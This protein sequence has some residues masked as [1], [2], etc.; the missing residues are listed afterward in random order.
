MAAR[1]Q[2][3]RPA[4]PITSV[5]NALRLIH[6]LR[7][8]G[9]VRGRDAALE[10]GISPSSVH[11]LMAMLVFRGFA[12]QGESRSYLPGPSIGVPAISFE[13]TRRLQ[14]LVRP[15]LLA[16]SAA[17]HETTYFSILAGQTVRFLLNVESTQPL[18]TG[19]RHGFVLPAATS[20]AGRAM[21]AA[22][23]PESIDAMFATD[24]SEE[25][26][27]DAAL[28]RLHLELDRVRVQG[29]ALSVEEVETGIATMAIPLRTLPKDPPAAISISV[30][31]LRAARLTEPATIDAIIA[32]RDAIESEVERGRSALGAL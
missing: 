14:E 20:A 2:R 22:K 23:S 9:E 27:D 3:R 8:V 1:P 21:L 17:V 24:E 32:T 18:H 6:M 10:L 31:T 16:L 29:Y 25:G 15:H 26:L 11:R 7:D 28:A 30:P 13:S 12:V 5:D 19:D 4:Y